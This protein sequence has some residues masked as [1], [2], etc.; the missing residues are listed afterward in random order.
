MS[1]ETQ[2]SQKHH[3]LGGKQKDEQIFQLEDCAREEAEPDS[4]LIYKPFFF[5][6]LLESNPTRVAVAPSEADP[7]L[8]NVPGARQAADSLLPNAA[9][10]LLRLPPQ[11]QEVKGQ[12]FAQTGQPPRLGP[13]GVVALMAGRDRGAELRAMEKGREGG[14]VRALSSETIH[15]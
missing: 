12:L 15:F 14:G 9:K 7:V 8:D 1:H 4:C 6:S 2:S 3:R 11:L 5:V 13:P 10:L